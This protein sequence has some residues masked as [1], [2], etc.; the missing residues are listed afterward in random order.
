[1]PLIFPKHHIMKKAALSLLFA[2]VT[3]LAMAQTTLKRV[4]NENSDPMAQIDSALAAVRADGAGRLVLCQVGGNWCPWCLRFA[5]FASR[6]A[7]IAKTLADNFAYIH[8]NYNPRKDGGER[9]QALMERLGQPARFGFPVFVVLDQ[10]GNVLHIQDSSF[11]EEGQGYSKE[12]TLRFL[13]AW[14]AKAVGKHNDVTRAI[15]ARRSVRRY[16]DRPVEHDKLAM[17]A[18]AGIK[19][20]SGM[21]SQPWAVRV[22]ES[23][24]WIEGLTALYTKANP[25]MVK[26][27]PNF[28]NMFRNAPNV[29]CVATPQGE[30]SVDAGMLG[31]NI[32]LAAQAMGLGT[33]CL[34]GPVRFLNTT[35]DCKPYL[36]RL[37]LPE[38]YEIC[39]ILAV[40]YPDESPEAKPRDE[41]KVMFVK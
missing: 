35:A 31:E 5:D 12:K 38:G 15:D 17:L 6:D 36:D 19:A 10:G 37:Q 9:A 33:C 3:T 41:S 28:K 20:P 11:L 16:L 26:R 29:I 22:V 8:V 7:D 23:R 18:Q 21:N 1:M 39:Y 27:D 2:L 32:M 4:Y 30:P 13:N 24:E 14:T 34:G 40:G 25:N